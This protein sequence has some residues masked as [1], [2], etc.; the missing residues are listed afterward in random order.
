M[1]WGVFLTTRRATAGPPPADKTMDALSKL[2]RDYWEY[3]LERSPTFA[4]Y[5]GDHRFGDRLGDLSDEAQT[6]LIGR[7]R[8]YREQARQI[9]TTALPD[10]VQLQALLFVRVLTDAIDG[11]D[12]KSV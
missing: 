9:D 12:R 1:I 5:L 11:A 2:F 6:K 10:S 4:T 8:E 7:L 3:T